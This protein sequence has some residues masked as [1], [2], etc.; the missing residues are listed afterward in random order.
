MRM[1]ALLDEFLDTERLDAGHSLDLNRAHTEL[2]ALCRRKTAEGM[3]IEPLRPLRVVA[4]ESE[5]V[6]CW[7]PQR[8]ERVLET[9]L[10]NAL[11]YSEPGSE[12]R[13]ELEREALPIAVAD[14]TA[15]ASPVAP[16]AVDLWRNH[17]SR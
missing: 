9:L 13:L 4:R 14:G 11:K 7:D 8:L 17:A 1:S 10:S 15:Q 2:V 16:L 3:V 6:G 5:L 12:I